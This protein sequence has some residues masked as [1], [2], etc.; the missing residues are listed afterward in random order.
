M[1]DVQYSD[2]NIIDTILHD[3]SDRL[4][5]EKFKKSITSDSYEVYS[6]FINKKHKY[7]PEDIQSLNDDIKDFWGI[8]IQELFNIEDMDLPNN[9]KIYVDVLNAIHIQLRN[10]L[11][12]HIRQNKISSN[13]ELLNDLNSIVRMSSGKLKLIFKISDISIVYNIINKCMDIYQN[14]LFLS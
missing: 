1:E 14:Y 7:T 5:F 6:K 10:V 11:F 8:N 12:D 9:F 2:T 13:E 3:E 4:I